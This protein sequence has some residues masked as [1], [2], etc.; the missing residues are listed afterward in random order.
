MGSGFMLE[1][2]VVW[3]ISTLTVRIRRSDVVGLNGVLKLGVP[4]MN[5]WES[6]WSESDLPRKGRASKQ[7]TVVAL[8][9]AQRIRDFRGE[10]RQLMTVTVLVWRETW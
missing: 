4:A 2:A 1:F 9:D 8:C 3:V 5:R 7:G 10:R 6:W